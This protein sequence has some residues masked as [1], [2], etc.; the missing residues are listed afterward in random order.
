M[1]T[2]VGTVEVRSLA[3]A[4]EAADTAVKAA[5]VEIVATSYALPGVVAVI[6]RGSVDAVAAAVAAVE[7]RLGMAGAMHGRSVLG[8][9]DAAV[10]QFIAERSIVIGRR[11]GA[12]AV[13]GRGRMHGQIPSGVP[14][15]GPETPAVERQSPGPTQ[16]VAR[17][18]TAKKASTKKTVAKKAAVKRTAAK[19][20]AVAKTNTKRQGSPGRD[21][22]TGRTTKGER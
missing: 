2:A 12:P 14:G 11:A 17:K 8:R 22:G 4:I 20:T 18:T 19:R 1:S 10:D 6:M 3:F 16:P 7:G 9:P 21:S 15:N 13:P 5:P